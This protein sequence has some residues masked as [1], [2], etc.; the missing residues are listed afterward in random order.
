MDILQGGSN[1]RN[2][3]QD[4]IAQQGGQLAIAIGV[5]TSIAVEAERDTSLRAID[6]GALFGINLTRLAV[7]RGAY[8]RGYIYAFISSFAPTLSRELVEESLSERGGDALLS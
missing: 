8:L 4:F 1:L 3:G 6:A 5:V 2:A 7:R